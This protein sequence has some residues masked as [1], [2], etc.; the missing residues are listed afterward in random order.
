MDDETKKT[1]LAIFDRIEALQ[2]NLNVSV[3]VLSENQ[4]C[5]VELIKAHH[6]NGFF[7]G[8]ITILEE[9]GRKVNQRSKE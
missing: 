5:I 1:F 7:D 3:R 4:K 9:E 2:N 6:D 8:N